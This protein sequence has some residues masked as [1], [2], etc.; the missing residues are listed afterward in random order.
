V[1]FWKTKRWYV[2]I[3]VYIVI[4]SLIYAL[5]K[6]SFPHIE[7]CERATDQNGPQNCA[8]YPPIRAAVAYIEVHNGLITAISTIVIALFTGT[9]WS[10]TR[11][12]GR[13]TEETLI[14]GRRAFVFAT[15]LVP[16]FDRDIVTGS[17]SWRFRPYLQNSGDAPTRHM[18]MYVDCEIR[19]SPLP[20]NFA[21]TED[22]KNVGNGLIP[23][24]A[25]LQSGQVPRGAPLSAHDIADAQAGKKYIYIWGWI[26]YRGAAAKSK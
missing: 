12:Q 17:Y 8:T 25:G 6:D 24:K 20:P 4:L 21:F 9:L 15:G 3:T 16:S 7:I 1:E 10:S 19:N 11:A 22:P 26:K 18:K 5:Y 14:A 13:L 23:P 2:E